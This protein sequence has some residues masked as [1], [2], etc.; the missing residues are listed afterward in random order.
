MHDPERVYSRDFATW[1]E[2]LPFALGIAR[3]LAR[4][5]SLPLDVDSIVMEA[6][7]KAQVSGAVLSKGYVRLRVTG[8]VKD[9][10]RRVAEG[11]RGN[12]QDAGAFVDVDDQWSLG[13]DRVLD[14][15]E[16]IDRRRALESLPG[17]ARVLVHEVVAGSR[18]RSWPRTTA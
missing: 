5:T 3:G 16:A 4:R 1:Q 10:M 9:E 12:Y 17:A 2:A 8:A 18:R 14:V 6:L 7:W 11:Q 15:V 13:D